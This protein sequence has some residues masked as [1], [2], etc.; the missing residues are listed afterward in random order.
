M[1]DFRSKD[2]GSDGS[3]EKEKKS[4]IARER[5]KR[6]RCLSSDKIAPPI[7][8]NTEAGKLARI[9]ILLGRGAPPPLTF[10]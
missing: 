10:R 5:K 6:W 4:N 1:A 7:D 9:T 8:P 2:T 3:K